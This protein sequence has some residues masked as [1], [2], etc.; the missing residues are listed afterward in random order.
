[1]GVFARRKIAPACERTLAFLTI[2]GEERP[3]FRTSSEVRPL[4]LA[5]CCDGFGEVRRL[6]GESGVVPLGNVS[7]DGTTRQ[8]H[9]SRHNAMRYGSRQTGGERWRAAIEALVT[10]ASQQEAEADAALGRQRGDAWPAEVARRADR[11]ATIEAALPRL[12]ARAKA[13]AAAAERQR[14]GTTRRGKAPTAVDETPD[15]TAP[16]R[17]P[18]VAEHADQ[19]PRL[20]LLWECPRQ[21]G[22]GVPDPRGV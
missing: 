12:E 10:Q 8:G 15:D 2:V 13:A 20:G 18:R 11:L 22:G 6:A 5:A 17:C 19:Q 14:T 4:P 3:D 21:C 1:V 7:T 9:A 16:L